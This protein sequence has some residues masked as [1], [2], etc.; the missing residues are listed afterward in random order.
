M[1]RRLAINLSRA[2]FLMA[3]VAFL[4]TTAFGQA[5]P[6]LISTLVNVNACFTRDTSQG[7][8]VFCRGGFAGDGG[9]AAKAQLSSPMG[10]AVDKAGNLFV[11]DNGNF[12][13]RRVDS[14]TGN[15]TTV[16]GDSPCRGG[17]C[18][19]GFSGDGGLATKA[20]LHNSF[21]GITLDSEGNLFICD[22]GNNR[23]R[24]VDR[25]TGIIRTVAGN[26]ERGFDGDGGPARSA[27]LDGPLGVA[28]D[29]SGNVFIAD[30]NNRRVRRVDS[31]TGIITTVAGGGNS[32]RFRGQ[33]TRPAPTCQ[34]LDA[35]LMNVAAV[36][37]NESGDL[38]VAEWMNSEVRRVDHVTGLIS[39][40]A[41]GVCPPPPLGG[42]CGAGFEGDGGPARD[43]R[44]RAPFSLAIDGAGNLFIADMGNGRVRR[45]DRATGTI[46]TVVGSGGKDYGRDGVPAMKASLNSPYGIAVNAEGNLFIAD[47]NGKSIRK[48][49]LASK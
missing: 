49:S 45:I 21:G 8:I 12:R 14:A 38:Y 20:R 40:V 44:L 42:S 25:A 18:V 36:L 27:K 13:V 19:G 43:A 46:T 39:W 5:N 2:C 1:K 17:A 11:S 22:S 7:P 28:V 34:A 24:R 15:I 29:A 32:C 33:G 48:V 3:A 4:A 41:G 9:P 47:T 16:A 26:G 37:V 30:S 31:A 35:G 23:V 6:N 10:V